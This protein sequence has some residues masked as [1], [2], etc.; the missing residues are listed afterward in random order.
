MHDVTHPSGLRSLPLPVPAAGLEAH[1]RERAKFL[2]FLESTKDFERNDEK[3][4]YVVGTG[5]GIAMAFR[6][7]L[8]C[9]I[10][11]V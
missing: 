1:Q 7:L 5:I 10:P 8:T 9:E 2:R 11:R 6:H 3:L 4:S